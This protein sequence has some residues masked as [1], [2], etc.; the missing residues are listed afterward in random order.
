MQSYARKTSDALHF[1]VE[2]AVQFCLHASRERQ[3][4]RRT[5]VPLDGVRGSA[6]KVHERHQRVFLAA[7]LCKHS[8][9]ANIFIACV[10]MTHHGSR[11]AR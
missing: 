1:V 5:P 11:G 9:R 6:R 8:F 10:L 4:G 2:T 3:S 7:T